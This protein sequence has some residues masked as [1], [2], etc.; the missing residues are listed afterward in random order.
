M[1]KKKKK[2]WQKKVGFFSLVRNYTAL[3][4]AWLLNLNMFGLSMKSVCSPG[5]NCHGCPWGTC[6][7]PVGIFTF[8]S[9]MHVI[10]ALA[11]A[12]I[13][14]V[15]AVLGRLACAFVCPFGLLQ[16]LLHKIPG[17]KFKLPKW[18]RQLKY[19]AL[20]ALV[21]VLPFWLGFEQEGYLRIEKV[22]FAADDA[23]AEE[24]GKEDETENEE[25]E[26]EQ[27][28]TED[29]EESADEKEDEAPRLKLTLTV[30]NLGEKPVVDPEVH[31]IFHE[32][33]EEE[34]GPPGKE[35]SR[36]KRVF[37]EIQIDPGET[38]T[39]PPVTVDD[40]REKHLIFADSPQSR[41]EQHP[42]H[43][44]YYCKLCPAGGLT[45][46]LPRLIATPE[47]T[48]SVKLRENALKLGITA[49]FL[50]LMVVVSRPFCRTF[51]PLGA[52]YALCSSLA[53]SSM[54]FDGDKCSGCGLC[55]KVCPVDIDPPTE[56]GNRDCILCGD[57][58]KVCPTGAIRRTFGFRQPVQKYRTEVQG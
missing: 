34:S 3:I 4:S 27:E 32:K 7:C 29:D 2:K 23:G 37:K 40:T 41:V 1:A 36:V 10:P 43:D 51:C 16:E 55:T 6:A 25:E 31:V 53:V 35:V 20:V 11:V 44:L 5:F 17:P 46:T 28:N 38:K 13:L 56:L 18:T 54:V 33:P 50:V 15:G 8:G 39:L 22:E 30:V 14:A 52:T 19:V 9:A 47:K 45:A 57:C 49:M 21:F 26:Q 42:R 24:D 48:W 58:Q 12:S